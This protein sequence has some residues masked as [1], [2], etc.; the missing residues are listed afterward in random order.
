MYRRRLRRTRERSNRKA[1]PRPRRSGE[2]PA[3]RIIRSLKAARG[4]G[5]GPA[6]VSAGGVM[7]VLGLMLIAYGSVAPSAHS[8]ESGFFLLLAGRHVTNEW[9]SQEELSHISPAREK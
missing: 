1:T 3:H 5:V 8:V 4:R 2:R 7:I 6:T 9:K